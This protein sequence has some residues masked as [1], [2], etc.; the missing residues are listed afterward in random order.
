MSQ[1]AATYPDRLLEPL[2]RCPTPEVAGRIALLRAEPD[3]QSRIN[4]LA[5]RCGEGLLSAEESDEYETYNQAI[6]FLSI[7]QAKA[8]KLLATEA[9]RR[10]VRSRA[11]GRCEYRGIAQVDLPFARFPVEHIIPRQHQRGTDDPANLALARDHRDA[12]KGTSPVAFD[13]ESGEAVPLS[14]PWMDL[15]HEHF[16]RLGDRIAGRTAIGRASARLL[17]MNTV[18]RIELRG[19]LDR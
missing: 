10:S 13:P 19:G 14:H 1:T 16:E 12:R 17:G 6:D 8:R 11:D 7:L 9:A 3:I 18:R 15:R 5:E 2:T 4:E